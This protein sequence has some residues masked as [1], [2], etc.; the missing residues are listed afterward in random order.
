MLLSHER[1]TFSPQGEKKNPALCRGNK[2]FEQDRNKWNSPGGIRLPFHQGAPSAALGYR[3]IYIALRSEDFVSIHEHGRVKSLSTPR[4]SM[5][6]LP[7]RS[8]TKR[9]PNAGANY[10]GGGKYFQAKNRP[11]FFLC[12]GLKETAAI[13]GKEAA[14]E[15]PANPSKEVGSLEGGFV[16]PEN[17][18]N[19]PTNRE[20]IGSP[21]RF[22][23]LDIPADRRPSCF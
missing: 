21:K 7:P 23:C 5:S 18:A 16:L 11:S 3:S 9:I 2:S 17:W 6:E 4:F 14:A 13:F 22:E 20:S 12:R 19:D 10:R 8:P 15:S 1:K